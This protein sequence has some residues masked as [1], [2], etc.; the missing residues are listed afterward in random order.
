MPNMEKYTI[1]TLLFVFTL[2]FYSYLN[3]DVY[4]LD[5]LDL[6]RF[7]KA[8]FTRVLKIEEKKSKILPFCFEYE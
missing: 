6:L 2:S 7:P 1:N 5:L 8:I 3:D 4:V